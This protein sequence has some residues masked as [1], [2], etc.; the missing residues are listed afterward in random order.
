MTKYVVYLVKYFNRGMYMYYC[1]YTGNIERRMREHRSGK[2][3]SLRNKHLAG[4]AIISSKYD[5]VQEAMYME[6]WV[7]RNFNHKQKAMIFT[8]NVVE[9]WE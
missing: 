7:K 4:Y 1:G 6:R 8:K 2:T 9:R 5:T 3:K